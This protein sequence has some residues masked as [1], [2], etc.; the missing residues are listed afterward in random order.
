[1]AIE[2]KIFEA[3]I[4]H[5]RLRPVENKFVY[6]QNY[7]AFSLYEL[8]KLKK[9]CFSLNKPNLF[10]FYEK[11]LGHHKSPI[12]MD[13]VTDTL[14]KEGLNFSDIS[15]IIVITSPRVFFYTFNPIS[16]FLIINK[17]N[18]L[19]AALAEVHNTY[20][21]PHTYIIIKDDQSPICSSDVILAKKAL[22]VSPF[23]EVKGHYEFR[24]NW[25]DQKFGAWITYLVD[26]EA[27]LLTSMVGNLYPLTERKL[28]SW[29]FT[30]PLWTFKTTILIHYQ[31]F[32]LWRKGLRY[33]SKPEPP[34]PSYTRTSGKKK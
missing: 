6:R 27:I 9:W 3:R 29:L 2:P 30:I 16:F 21:E 15:D 11:D 12:L 34:V 19:I 24:F 22:H 18:E 13:W 20:G 5:K 26:N 8:G 23:F 10:A 4:A 31:A 1:M 17:T 32:L 28:L 33:I 14:K 25:S 7:A